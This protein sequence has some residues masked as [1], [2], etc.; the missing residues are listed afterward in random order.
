[1]GYSLWRE[2]NTYKKLDASGYKTDKS[3]TQYLR[4]YERYFSPFVKKKIKLL[5]LGVNKGGSLLLWRDYFEKGVIVGLDINPV[6][7]DD[8]TGRIHVYQG[9]Q[10][11]LALLD[12][13]SEEV[14]PEGF[15]VIIDDCSHIGELTRISFW[16]LFDNHL[17]PGGIYSIEDWGTGYWDR[18]FDG[19]QYEPRA[20]SDSRALYMS[21]RLTSFVMKIQPLSKALS[22]SKLVSSLLTHQTHEFLS[23][24]YG[25]VG[26]IKELVDE[27]G[28]GDITH[29]EFGIS[30][31]R[32]SKFAEMNIFHGQVIIVKS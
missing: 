2:G 13:I 24:N 29:P 11:D 20:K 12:R 23:H 19:K 22:S 28:M 6:D 7:L 27:A 3:K 25:M 4:N 21:A 30:P 31:H 1:M 16:H 17:K 14:A 32:P 10:Q 5:E 8:P 9:Q 26:V 15:D 18:S